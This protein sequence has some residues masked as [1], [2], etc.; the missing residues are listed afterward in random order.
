MTASGDASLRLIYGGLVQPINTD[1]IPSWNTI[2]ERLQDAPWHTVDSVHY[3]VPY[4]WGA[5]VLM[6]NTDVFPEPPTSWSV[7]FEEQPLPDGES[8]VGRV[9]AYDGPIYIADAALYLMAHNPDLG[10]TDP[11]FEI[12]KLPAEAVTS[13]T[14]ALPEGDNYVRLSAMRRFAERLIYYKQRRIWPAVTNVRRR[15]ELEAAQRLRIPFVTGPGVC[16]PVP[17]PVGGRELPL[18]RMPMTLS[19]WM[20]ARDRSDGAARAAS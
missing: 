20:G 14:L 8:N 18:E 10:I 16:S 12:E 3:G 2:D 17:G 6:Y 5:N 19:E 4:Q 1:L 9:Q 7:V 15:Q 13:V 11:G